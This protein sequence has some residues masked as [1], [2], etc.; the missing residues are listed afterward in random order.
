MRAYACAFLPSPCKPAA[1]VCPTLHPATAAETCGA[2]FALNMHPAND[3]SN[4]SGGRRPLTCLRAARIPP[5][6]A[7]GGSELCLPAAP[8]HLPAGGRYNSMKPLPGQRR[9]REAPLGRPPARWLLPA[10]QA[11]MAWGMVLSQACICLWAH[12][13]RLSVCMCSTQQRPCVHAC[14]INQGIYQERQVVALGV[15]GGRRAAK[16]APHRLAPRV[17]QQVR[18]HRV[19]LRVAAACS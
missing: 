8:M 18:Q 13:Q 6:V 17:A 2:C 3:W 11:L 9:Q 1:A 10:T 12:V 19:K 4:A 14:S 16:L 5:L 15:A 7:A